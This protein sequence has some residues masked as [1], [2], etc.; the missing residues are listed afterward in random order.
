MMDGVGDGRGERKVTGLWASCLYKI[1]NRPG[2][3]A[4]VADGPLAHGHGG[5][6]VTWVVMAGNTGG[7]LADDPLAHGHK[8]GL[9]AGVAD[10]L[11]HGHEA[12]LVAGV[13]DDPIAHCH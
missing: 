10:H 6:L 4:G 13:A 9:I 8:A 3:V 5:V 11:A 7:P 1:F 12:G 2:L